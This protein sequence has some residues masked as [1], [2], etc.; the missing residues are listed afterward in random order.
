MNTFIFVGGRTVSNTSDLIF[1]YEQD[2]ENWT[3]LSTRDVRPIICH[4]IFLTLQSNPLNG[5]PDNGS[6]RL[7]V[8][9]LA[10]LIS[11]LSY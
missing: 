8:Q 1:Q 6:I 11:V 2:E 4:M 7:L 5:S 10:N 9:V 3:I